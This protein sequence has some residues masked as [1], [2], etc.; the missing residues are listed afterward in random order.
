MGFIDKPFDLVINLGGFGFAVF[1]PE[2]KLSGRNIAWRGR[3]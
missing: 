3:S 2:E 1:L